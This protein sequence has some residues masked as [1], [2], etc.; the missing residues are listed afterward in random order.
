MVSKTV[1]QM[2]DCWRVRGT[3]QCYAFNHLETNFFFL[4][5]VKESEEQAQVD[6]WHKHLRQMKVKCIFKLSAVVYFTPY[7]S[8]CLIAN[9]LNGLILSHSSETCCV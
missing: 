3:G 6:S 8:L 4:I 7:L 5:V 9:G 2:G 1:T